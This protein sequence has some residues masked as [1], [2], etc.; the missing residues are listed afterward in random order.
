[1]IS[2]CKY[3]K[4]TFLQKK[5]FIEKNT[6]LYEYQD[7]Y[8]ICFRNINGNIDELKSFCSSMSEFGTYIDFSDLFERKLVEY[9]IKI[10]DKNAVGIINKKFK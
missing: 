2:F 1:M 10:I 6:T 4:K 3:A 9:G 8:Y 5:F 7:N